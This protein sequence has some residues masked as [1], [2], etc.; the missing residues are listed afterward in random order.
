MGYFAAER[1]FPIPTKDI[2]SWTFDAPRYD[3]DE[4]I[5]IDA[6]DPSRSI[7]CNQARVLV[8]KIVAGLHAAGLKKGDCVCLH[9]FNDIH[10]PILFLGI[11]AAGG[12]FAGSNPSYTHFELVHHIKTAR[13]KF[14]VT[15][16]EMLKN[17]MSAAKEC[18]VPVSQVWIFDVQATPLPRGH[19]SWRDLLSHGEEDWVR[20]DDEKTAK[21]T[22]AARL[23]SSGTTGPP[24][25][26]VWSHH[27]C[28]AQYTL[29]HEYNPKTWRPVRILSLPMF[30]AGCVPVAHLTPLRAGQPSI[31]MRRFEL[32]PFLANIEKFQINEAGVVPPIV[33]SIIMSGLAKKYSL[34]TIRHLTVGAA[35]LGRES[36]EKIRDLLAPGAFV[37]QVWGMT[38]TSC[39]ASMFYFPEDDTT[40][41][42]GR[43]LPNVDAKIIDEEGNDITGYDVRGELCVRGPIVV[44][45]Y[46]ENPKANAES[47]DADGF[48]RTGDIAYCD[49]KTKKWY[50]VD[51]KKDL[52]KVRGFQVAPPELE[53]LLL[54]H[55]HIVDAG[56]IGVKHATEADVEL[57]RAYVVRRDTPEGQALTEDAVKKHCSERLAGFKELTGGVRFLDA[58]PKNA[59][60]KIL[61]KLL[62]D[63]AKEEFEQSRKARL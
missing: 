20:F 29:V 28:V 25:A 1:R 42:V 57:P 22:T 36:Q 12:V 26:A 51:R 50:V 34:K 9:S 49:S 62:R 35:P 46:L 30:H 16:P 13:I 38:E 54:G 48:F 45:G 53:T 32:E 63:L 41:S 55:P 8:R 33:I 6:T 31:V 15:E 17:V 40:G 60:G 3:Q 5:Y 7:S 56:V 21:E 39:I 58:I 27:N 52:I 59:S 43:M 61:K 10:Y 47:F 44:K 23:F 24:K 2:L 14:L 37:A 11:I 18:G 4:P 19:K